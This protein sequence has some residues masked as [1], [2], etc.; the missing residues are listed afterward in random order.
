M[1]MSEVCIDRMRPAQI[2]NCRHKADVAFLPLGAIEWHGVHNPQ[3][4]DAIKAHHICCEA[5]RKLGGGA[6]FPALVWGVPR[7]SFF[8]NKLSSHGD[9][10]EPISRGLGAEHAR[11]NGLG[12]HGGM[13]VQEQWLFYQRLVRMSLEQIA[14]YGFKSI[15]IVTGHN[16]LIYWAKPVAIAFARASWMAGHAVNVDCGSESDAAGLN[17]TD[18]G[19][20]WETSI[21]MAIDP[22]TVDL[23]ELK[24]HEDYQFIGCGEDAL[25]STAQQG[26][27]WIDTCTDAIARD[28]RWLAD[29]HPDL[30][31]HLVSGR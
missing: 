28:A 6:V 9:L 4:V 1:D 30:P 22:D 25:E 8:M 21:T 17:L 26:A 11:L 16:P 20:K 29:H 23:D 24:Q 5:A 18:H 15:Y 14:S 19:G 31:A 2:A 7:D 27:Q 10:S 12:P 13:D 3:G